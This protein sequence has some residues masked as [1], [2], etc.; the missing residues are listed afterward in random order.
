[1]QR[2]DGD[3]VQPGVAAQRV[4]EAPD[5]VGGPQILVL[6]VDQAVRAGDD[7]VV[8]VGD[9]AFA[10]GSERV[11]VPAAG[12][13]PQH[14]HRHGSRRASGR[15]AGL[16]TRRRGR[17]RG[18]SG[19]PAGR[20]GSGSAARGRPTVRGTPFPGRRRPVRAPP[21]GCRARAASAR[22]PRPSAGVADRRR[23]RRRRGGCDTGRCHRR[24]RR[25]VPA[26]P[27]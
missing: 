20:R 26:R 14:L 4:G 17:R 3:Q 15:V 6:Q 9:A 11:T 10:V 18:G 23:G 12:V 21:A 7:L 1:M 22:R 25:R 24:T 2:N 16:A 13:G 19:R 5:D 8:G 27:G